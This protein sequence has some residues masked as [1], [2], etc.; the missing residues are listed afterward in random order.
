[1]PRPPKKKTYVVSKAAEKGRLDAQDE[2]DSKL[3]SGRGKKRLL[4]SL[5]THIGKAIDRVEPLELVAVLGAT[6]IVHNTIMNAPETLRYIQQKALGGELGFFEKLL[7]YGPIN[8]PMFTAARQV[9]GETEKAV[10]EGIEQQGE[11]M[12]WVISFVVAYL[13]IKHFGLIISTLGEMGKSILSLTNM[14]L[15]VA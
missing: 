9:Y 7:L 1:M 12:V 6:V 8:W 3:L 5:A 2:H 13:C 11:I 14:Q 4:A 10:T 15:G